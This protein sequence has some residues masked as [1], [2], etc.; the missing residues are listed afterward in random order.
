MPGETANSRVS[1]LENKVKVLENKVNN[2]RAEF[3]EQ[4]GIQAE[5]IHH[6]SNALETLILNSKE[7]K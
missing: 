4:I 5:E 7:N 3:D 6:L 1:Q 2:L